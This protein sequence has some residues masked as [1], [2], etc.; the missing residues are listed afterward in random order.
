VIWVVIAEALLVVVLGVFVLALIHS[1]AG[2]VAKVEES[3]LVTPRRGADRTPQQRSAAASSPASQ[4]TGVTPLGDGVVLP[5]VGVDHDTLLAFLTST[6]TSCQRLWSELVD[7]DGSVLPS[8]LRLVV[9]PKGPDQESPAAILAAAPDS[10]DVVMSSVAWSDFKVPGSPYFVLVDGASGSVRGE[11][12]A[13]SWPRVVDLAAVATG[14]DRLADGI[15]HDPRKP[16]GDLRREAEVDRLLLD[17]GIL[18]GDPSLY[19]GRE[20]IEAP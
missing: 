10:V 6:C 15:A 1:Y 13:L 2:L 12:T 9:V 8:Q 18:P 20:G 17:A 5:L 19:P 3:S 4:V 16:T 7:A 14:D 11:G